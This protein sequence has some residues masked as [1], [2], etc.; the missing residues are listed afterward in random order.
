MTTPTHDLTTYDI[1][2]TDLTL[3]VGNARRGDVASIQSSIEDLGLF[4][5]VVVNRGTH[6]GRPMEVLSGNHT[7]QAAVRAG[8]S[9]IAAVVL[10]VDDTT[11]RQINLRANKTHDDGTYDLRA[12]A[13]LLAPF[14]DN[15]TGTGYAAADV[16]RILSAPTVTTPTGYTPPPG[17]DPTDAPE[18][19]PVPMPGQPVP[20]A[21]DPTA[22]WTGM[23]TDPRG[24]TDEPVRTLTVYFWTADAWASF[25][26]W[27]GRDVTPGR[28]SVH[29]PNTAMVGGE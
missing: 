10:D 28:S 13:A 15:P 14:R 27:L 21:N 29:V 1:P 18:P 16:V 22:E 26:R 24:I 17:G 25:T 23:D 2:I 4:Q 5:P 11:A 6:T 9:T 3:F 19:P 8:H 20:P 7:V 12:L